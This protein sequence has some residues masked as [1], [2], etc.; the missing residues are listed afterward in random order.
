[1]LQIAAG[2]EPEATNLFLQML[3][4]AATGQVQ[5]SKLMSD[6]LTRLMATMHLDIAG[7]IQQPVPIATSGNASCN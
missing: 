3:A 4:R 2:L 6:G 1:M 7:W 5:A